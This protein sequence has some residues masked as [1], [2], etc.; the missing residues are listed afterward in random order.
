MKQLELSA[1]RTQAGVIASPSA[2]RLWSI[3]YRSNLPPPAASRTAPLRATL[4]AT[5]RQER[6]GVK[7]LLSATPPEDVA[8]TAMNVKPNLL[9][10]S[11]SIRK[12]V[13]IGANGLQDWRGGAGSRDHTPDARPLP[14]AERGTLMG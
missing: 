13:M 3:T 12:S 11:R 5:A 6:A 9:I 7:T 2:H 8:I 10:I 4:S 14:A 1:D